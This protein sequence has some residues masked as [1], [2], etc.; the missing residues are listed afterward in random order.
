MKIKSGF[1]KASSEGTGL[2]RSVD[3]ATLRQKINEAITALEQYEAENPDVNVETILSAQ[4]G[5]L[6]LLRRLSNS[7]VGKFVEYAKEQGT[8]MPF[9]SM[10]MGIL[11]AGRID[12]QNGLAEIANSLKFGKQNC[13]ECDEGMDNRGR[14]KKKL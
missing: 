7:E 9:D 2:E 5:M 11:S 13:Q 10:E 14:G 12:M 8:K 6:P 3:E 4:A 1:G